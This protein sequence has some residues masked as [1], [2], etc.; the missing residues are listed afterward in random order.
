[1]RL[2]LYCR[3]LKKA[4]G[5][6]LP[7]A[8]QARVGQ[9]LTANLHHRQMEAIRIIQRIVFRCAI[10]EAEDLLCDVTI[11]VEGLN[12]N[13]GATQTALQ[14]APEIFDALRVNLT[15]NV[16]F[17]VIDVL[18]HKLLR[19]GKALVGCWHYPCRS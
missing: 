10:V 3:G 17:N 8:S 14:K 13:I 6:S 11:K 2:P 16:L 4:S 9:P 5:R 19:S 12:R 15:A 18:M 1:M 7:V